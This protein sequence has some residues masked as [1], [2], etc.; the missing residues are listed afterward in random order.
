LEPFKRTENQTKIIEAMEIYFQK[1][2]DSKKKMNRELVVLKDGKIVRVK[3]DDLKLLLYFIKYF[4]IHLFTNF[5]RQK[6][7]YFQLYFVCCCQNE[8]NK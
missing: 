7:F 5:I 2:L 8:K 6:Y 1:L 4:F 3:P